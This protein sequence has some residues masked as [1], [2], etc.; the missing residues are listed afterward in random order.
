M[1]VQAKQLTY[2]DFGN[3]LIHTSKHGTMTTRIIAGVQTELRDLYITND[4]RKEVKSRIKA[5]YMVTKILFTD[6]THIWLAGEEEVEMDEDTTPMEFEVREPYR[7][8]L[9]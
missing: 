5:S 1:K 9:R 8:G 7:T 2:E 4:P 6:G 3:R